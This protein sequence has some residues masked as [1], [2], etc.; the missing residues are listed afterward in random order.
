MHYLYVPVSIN[1]SPFI[2]KVAV[3]EYGPKNARRAYNLQRIE[4]SEVPRAQ[5]SQIL[6]ENREIYAYT[7]DAL[8]VSQMYDYSKQKNKKPSLTKRN[9]HCV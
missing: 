4:L 5:F 2:A 7:S 9:E 1:E 8:T 6:L 3:E